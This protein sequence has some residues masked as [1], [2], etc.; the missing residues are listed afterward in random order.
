M[1][2]TFVVLLSETVDGGSTGR[3]SEYKFPIS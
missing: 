2:D 1:Y 3:M